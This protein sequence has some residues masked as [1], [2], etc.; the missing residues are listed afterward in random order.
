[1]IRIIRLILKKEDVVIKKRSFRAPLFV[2]F[3]LTGR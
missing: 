1:M 2:D 3:M